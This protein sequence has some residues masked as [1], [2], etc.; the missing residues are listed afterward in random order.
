PTAAATCH[1]SPATSHVRRWTICW[2]SWNHGSPGAAS[3]IRPWSTRQ[4]PRRLRDS[5][6]SHQREPGDYSAL[7][8]VSSAKGRCPKTC[9]PYIGAITS[10][11]LPTLV[12]FAVFPGWAKALEVLACFVAFDQIPAQFVEPFL[13]GSGIGISPLMLIVAALY[14]SWLWGIVGLILA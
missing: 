5:D 12:A 8:G 10:A 7:P 1:R 4:L 3:P 2:R 11:V 6:S 14:W 13:I 9:T